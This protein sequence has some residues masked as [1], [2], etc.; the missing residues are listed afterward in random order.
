VADS[1]GA[2]DEMEAELVEGGRFVRIATRRRSSGKPR[3]VTL[4]FVPEVDGSI[5]VAAGSPDAAWAADLDADPRAEATVG[6]RSW[7]VE[8]EPLE[9]AE[10]GRTV[11]EMIL[12]YGTPAESL[13]SGSAFRL[14]PLDAG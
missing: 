3:T 5:L 1:S 9:P 10:A 7:P 4:G 8:A 12:R 2:R 11:R 13:G 6:H 14:R